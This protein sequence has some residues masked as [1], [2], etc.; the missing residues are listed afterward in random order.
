VKAP[1]T[2]G[3]IIVKNWVVEVLNAVL[4]HE[5]QFDVIS[6]TLTSRMRRVPIK[7]VHTKPVKYTHVKKN[8]LKLRSPRYRYVFNSSRL[9]VC[10][11]A[12]VN[13]VTIG[14]SVS[15]GLL[16]SSRLRVHPLPITNA[17]NTSRPLPG[18]CLYAC[19]ARS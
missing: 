9:A 11:H 7:Y 15:S 17:F 1:G 13:A 4:R 3:Y 10:V 19:R 12:L 6:K 8:L 2:F 5:M 14:P 16:P 18:H